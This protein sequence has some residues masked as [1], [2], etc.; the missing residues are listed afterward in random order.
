VVPGHAALPLSRAPG[1][2]YGVPVKYGEYSHVLISRVA[3]F[4]LNTMPPAPWLGSQGL[5]TQR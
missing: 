1:D 4:G 5:L 2:G 3:N